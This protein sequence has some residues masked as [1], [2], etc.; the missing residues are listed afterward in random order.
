MPSFSAASA[1]NT[2]LVTATGQIISYIRSPKD[3]KLNKYAQMIETPVTV[4]AY[5]KYDR[6]QPVRVVTDAD[7][8]FADG[9]DRPSGDWNQPRFK[10]VEF[11]VKRRDYPVRIG[12]MALKQAQQGLKLKEHA[13]GQIASQ[14]MT[15]KTSRVMDLIETTANWGTATDTAN[16]LNGGAGLWSTASDTPGDPNY[17]AIKKTLTNCFVR[18]N[19]TT[20]AVVQPKDL[21]LV[22]N[23]ELAM[24]MAN[25][26]EL[27]NYLKYGPFSKAQLE[28]A[29]FNDNMVWGLPPT[30]Y[31]VELVVEDSPYVS[32]R[33]TVSDADGTRAYAKT[34]DSAVLCSRKGGIN[35]TYGAPSFS[36]I[37]IYWHEWE[38]AVYTFDDPRHLRTEMHVMDCYSEQLAAPEAGFLIRS[39]V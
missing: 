30:L 11:T 19:K 10:W 7:F 25:T 8:V 39:V 1:Y 24:T 23:P 13:T 16:N 2:L 15:N 17:N 36:T 31:G 26:A 18:I 4:G 21:L 27:H 6:D 28:D 22:I 32:S 33:P 35:G 37:Q 29:N 5:A 3:F 14:A 12:D 38:M 34:T 20:N 9:A